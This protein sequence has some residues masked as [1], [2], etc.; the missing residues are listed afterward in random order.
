MRLYILTTLFATSAGLFAQTSE[1]QIAYV[2][3]GRILNSTSDIITV[4]ADSRP[5]QEMFALK[6]D[7]I[8]LPPGDT[9]KIS[10]MEWAEEFRPPLEFY[11]FR[12]SDPKLD[13]LND[14]ENWVFRKLNE[15]TGEF[16]Y[17]ITE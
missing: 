12:T 11:I 2:A 7:S 15:T 8:L 13:S 14:K 5:G 3:D 10:S 4:W 9:T 6:A 16:I 17:S 1:C